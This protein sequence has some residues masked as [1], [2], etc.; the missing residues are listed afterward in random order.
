MGTSNSQ[1]GME[2]DSSSSSDRS[3]RG[4]GDERPQQQSSTSGYNTRSRSGSGRTAMSMLS[5][6]RALLT[7][8][9]L[10]TLSSRDL[11]ILS[12]S[13]SPWSGSDDDD[14]EEEEEGSSTSQSSTLK[15]ET[16]SLEK[17]EFCLMTKVGCGLKP[18]LK[19]QYSKPPP[20]M[21]LLS[22]RETGMKGGCGFSSRD[23]SSTMNHFL[24]NKM[25]VED[26]YY[27]KAF[28]GT[29]SQDGEYF[30]SACQDRILRLYRTTGKRFT[31]L[32][33]IAARD[34]GWSILDTAFS[35]DGSCCVYSSWSDSVFLVRLFG[36]SDSQDA[37][38]LTP[39]DS[40]FCVFSLVF[41]QDGQ[42]VLCGAN[43]GYLYIYDRFSNQRVLKIEGH[44]GDVN[45]VAYADST[46]HILYSGSDD[47][48]CKVWDRRTLSESDPKPVGVLAG[49]LDGITFIEPRGDGR[50]F[51]SNSKDQTIKLWDVRKFSS[52][53]CQ[54]ESIKAA[55]NGTWD[56]R[57]Q[58][59][60]TKF[61]SSHRRLEGDTSVMTYRGHKVLQTL[62]RCR[63]SPAVSTGQRYIYT[64]CA[65]GRVLIYDA[66]T[67]QPIKT[68]LGHR[69]CVR[70]VSWHPYKPEIVS[71][72]WDCM[73]ARWQHRGDTDDYASDDEFSSEEWLGGCRR[74]ASKGVRHARAAR[75]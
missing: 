32:R 41:S 12:R 16:E 1:L 60:P 67:G 14:D 2:G 75:R 72:G 74:R 22:Q 13:R 61:K 71:T 19:S 69:A 55:A 50:H 54:R 46:S 62:I 30:L 23:L 36:D 21:K 27:H 29:Y 49:H 39:I 73:V 66:L 53:E 6:A 48:L 63:F 33:K 10:G 44:H 17:S 8:G 9:S 68:L 47:S 25:I 65:H 58:Q 3:E 43:D 20:V 59:V 38:Q 42:E 31:L 34:V 70:D 4:D 40:R 5:A 18:D 15:A 7:Q 37:L 45:T 57:Y 52:E 64:G 11:P 28:C 24:P 26:Q 56:Y 51:L 35:P